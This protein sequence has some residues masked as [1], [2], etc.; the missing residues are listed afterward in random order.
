MCLSPNLVL[1]DV[2][3]V[4][5]LQCHLVSV[6]CLVQETTC[7]VIFND[8]CCVIQE[9]L[10]KTEIGRG[11]LRN[12]VY[13]FASYPASALVVK[14][15]PFILHQRLG[16]PSSDVFPFLGYNKTGS[17]IKKLQTCEICFLSKQTQSSFPMILLPWPN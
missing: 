8:Q 15:D 7:H 6:G 14:S 9:R 10:S 5:N 3:Y 2:L 17:V 12:G 11:E 1:H 16:H 4:P 13:V